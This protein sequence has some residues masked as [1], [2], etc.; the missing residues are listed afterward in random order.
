VRVDW[1]SLRQDNSAAVQRALQSLHFERGDLEFKA[2]T[3]EFVEKHQLGDN[4][5][6][7]RSMQNALAMTYYKRKSAHYLFSSW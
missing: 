5:D 2:A 3:G 4:K 1:Q 7:G 6:H